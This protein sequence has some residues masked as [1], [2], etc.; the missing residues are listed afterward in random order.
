MTR[1]RRKRRSRSA[2]AGNGAARRGE[3]RE[4]ACGRFCGSGFEGRRTGRS[5]LGVRAGSGLRAGGRGAGRLLG[6][7]SQDFLSDIRLQGF[8]RTHSAISLLIV[9]DEHGKNTRQG[10]GGIVQGVRKLCFPFSILIADI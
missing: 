1:R 10:D 5:V 7:M 3:G 8:R 6:C 9:L 2:P 4:T